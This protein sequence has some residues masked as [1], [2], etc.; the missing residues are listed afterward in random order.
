[1]NRDP[2]SHSRRCACAPSDIM[3]QPW[4]RLLPRK[5]GPRGRKWGRGRRRAIRRTFPLSPPTDQ[6]RIRES[7]QLPPLD[8]LSISAGRFARKGKCDREER[9]RCICTCA[10]RDFSMKRSSDVAKLIFATSIGKSIEPPNGPPLS[11]HRTRFGSQST[12]TKISVLLDYRS[13]PPRAPG[14]LPATACACARGMRGA[15]AHGMIVAASAARSSFAPALMRLR[16]L[17]CVHLPWRCDRAAAA[18]SREPRAAA[19]SRHPPTPQERNYACIVIT[20]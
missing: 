8:G 20:V 9:R 10:R 6:K 2:P 18:L 4:P 11:L 1:M 16:G 7:C 5:I 12:N 3:H 17:H 19:S 13:A 15:L 14:A